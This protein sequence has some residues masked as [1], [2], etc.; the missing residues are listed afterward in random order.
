ML[1]PCQAYQVFTDQEEEGE[2]K[3]GNDELL[4]NATFYKD[5]VPINIYHPPPHHH[6]QIQNDHVIGLLISSVDETDSG[7]EYYCRVGEALTLSSEVSTIYIGGRLC[8]GRDRV[9]CGA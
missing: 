5:S 2:E 3:E 8:D 1:I 6:I 4:L 7:S 9:L